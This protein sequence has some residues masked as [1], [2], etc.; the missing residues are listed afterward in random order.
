VIKLTREISLENG[1]TVSFYHHTHR[2]FG[3]YHRIKVEIICEVPLLEEYFTNSAE[4][5]D[6]NASL[7]GKVVFRRNLELM[8]VSSA[9]LE[10][11]L[12]SVIDNFSSH[13]LS[14][15]ASPLFPRKLVHAELSGA[16]RKT[17]KSG[18]YTG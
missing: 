18:V 1:L 7:G 3:D 9:E 10:Q 11:S 13:A 2:Y 4:F 6:A 5:A 8:G 17:H 14:Y 12:E 15:L 16:A